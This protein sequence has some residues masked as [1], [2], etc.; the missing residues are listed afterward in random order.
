MTESPIYKLFI[1]N[2][3]ASMIGYAINFKNICFKYFADEA[4]ETNIYTQDEIEEM[5]KY[6]GYLPYESVQNSFTNI[7]K[8]NYTFCELTII[9]SCIYN[10]NVLFLDTINIINIA[11]QNYYGK[12]KIKLN[13]DDPEDFINQV[14]ASTSKYDPD[15]IR[16]QLKTIKKVK[17][18]IKC[19]MK[20]IDNYILPVLPGRF[21]VVF[22]LKK[23]TT[24]KNLKEFNQ[25]FSDQDL[26]L[27]K[28]NYKEK[29]NQLY[30][31]I[32]EI[33][34]AI[35]DIKTF[36]EIFHFV[37][38]CFIALNKKKTIQN[39]T[40]YRLYV[41][42]T[43]I[44]PGYFDKFIS[45]N[46]PVEEICFDITKKLLYKSEFYKISHNYYKNLV[47]YNYITSK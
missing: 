32:I 28:K 12:G 34:D 20:V 31:F 22:E 24:L 41:K 19:Q 25:D 2:V 44:C 45:V 36:D 33:L 21:R 30:K 35:E 43:S 6:S 3:Y 39:L 8:T 10:N 37:Y 13:I 1:K 23:D 38:R 40:K 26:D 42:D 46:F 7:K 47:L 18:G 29:N 4:L 9:I 17:L 11:I 16:N 14:M 15:V 5:K 27:L